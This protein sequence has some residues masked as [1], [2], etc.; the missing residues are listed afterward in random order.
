MAYT[1]KS[2]KLNKTYE[3]YISEKYDL[4]YDILLKIL[5]NYFSTRQK[6]DYA[7]LEDLYYDNKIFNIMKNNNIYLCSSKYYPT[8][9]I[10]FDELHKTN[11]ILGFCNPSPNDNYRYY[12]L[13]T[14]KDNNFK[15][16]IIPKFDYSNLWNFDNRNCIYE[17][18]Y[19]NKLCI[20]VKH[21]DNFDNNFKITI[22]DINLD[23]KF[24]IKEYICNGL[25]F[26]QYKDITISNNSIMIYNTKY[27]EI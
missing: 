6:N 2:V 4:E 24:I 9:F 23:Y 26:I 19:N 25:S 17:R 21:R 18:L 12:S 10:I 20:F 22:I 16:K 8:M 15:F 14:I 1:D 7:K 27:I 11:F 13:I 3:T 5:Q